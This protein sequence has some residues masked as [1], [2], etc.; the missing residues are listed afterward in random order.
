MQS[1]RARIETAS[2]YNNFRK[3]KCMEIIDPK[4]PFGKKRKGGQEMY[5]PRHLQNGRLPKSGARSAAARRVL[6]FAVLCAAAVFLAA[7]GGTGAYFNDTG[8]AS[9]RFDIQIGNR[10]SAPATAQAAGSAESESASSAAAS[11][12]TAAEE[13]GAQSGQ[14]A[15]TSPAEAG[16]PEASS[17]ESRPAGSVEPMSEPEATENENSAF[18]SSEEPESAS[19]EA[20]AESGGQSG[21]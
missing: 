4:K 15:E 16:S 21:R 6:I 10:E 18:R 9:A 19:D 13:P 14:A 11:P 3:R 5:R 17:E 1:Y 8:Q 2:C 12:E 20:A 7:R